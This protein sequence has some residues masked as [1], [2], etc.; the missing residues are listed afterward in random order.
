MNFMVPC[1]MV[2][3]IVNSTWSGCAPNS[4]GYYHGPLALCRNVPESEQ[5]K[6]DPRDGASFYAWQMNYGDDND[7]DWSPAQQSSN[8]TVYVYTF[9]DVRPGT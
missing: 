8:E 2:P 3:S 7:T 5:L 6:C 4:T 9:T 1:S